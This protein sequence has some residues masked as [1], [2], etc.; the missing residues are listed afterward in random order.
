MSLVALFSISQVTNEA[1]GLYSFHEMRFSLL[2][3]FIHWVNFSTLICQS[4]S[5]AGTAHMFSHPRLV[6][7]LSLDRLLESRLFFFCPPLVCASLES[8]ALL[9]L[10]TVLS[11]SVQ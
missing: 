11:G 8:C 9:V 6:L 4:S 2:Y 10:H 5:H 1:Q 3:L 7:S